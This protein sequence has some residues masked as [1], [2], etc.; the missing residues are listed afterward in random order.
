MKRFQ[1]QPEMELKQGDL[2]RTCVRNIQYL[3]RTTQIGTTESQSSSGVAQ[4]AIKIHTS[5][6]NRI[7]KKKNKKTK[8]V[9]TH[10][11]ECECT[12]LHIKCKHQRKQKPK[13]NV[14][15]TSHSQTKTFGLGAQSLCLLNDFAQFSNVCFLFFFYVRLSQK[16][17]QE[18]AASA[19][20]L[21]SFLSG[22]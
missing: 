11:R 8:T 9:Y 20:L 15:F 19:K 16:P 7:K 13:K 3:K 12:I 2:F 18:P 6:L 17:S 22:G 4:W 21:Y 10:C 14:K 5:D 1:V